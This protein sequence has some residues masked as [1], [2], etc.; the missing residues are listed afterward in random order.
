MDIDLSHTHTHTRLCLYVLCGCLHVC[1][2]YGAFI[3]T[4]HSRLFKLKYR[5]FFECI[6]SDE[7]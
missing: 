7:F 6:F 4:D 3:F 5:L 2:Y 1:T